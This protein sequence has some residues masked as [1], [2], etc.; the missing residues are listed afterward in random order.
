LIGSG[1]STGTASQRLQVTGGAYVSGR[2][3]VANTNPS[4]V[5]DVT[6]SIGITTTS[7]DALIL[8]STLTNGRTSIVLNT[9]GNDWELGSRGSGSSPINSFYIYDRNASAYRQV[10]DP[11]GNVLFGATSATGTAS[12][13]LQVTGGGYFSGSVGIGSTNPQSTLSVGGTITEL[14][15][16]TYWNVVTQ[17]DVGYGSSQVPLNQYL[18]QLA[19][20]DDFSPNGLRREG[21]GSDD[22]GISS[23]GYV[24][25]GTTNPTSKLHVVGDGY[26]TGIVTATDFNSASDENLKTNIVTIDDPL[27][28]IVQIRGVNFEWR[29]NGR[30]SAGVIAQEIEKVLPELVNGGETKTVNYNGLIGLLIEAIKAQQEEI[31]I[32]KEKIK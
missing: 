16:G 2:L 30:R 27:D 17:A 11:S 4:Y 3:G 20:L 25:I 12:Q 15:A 19:F 1:T 18:G 22:V 10:I 28:K 5:I 7:G 13:L 26:F 14:Y 29:E 6:G 31:D 8:S 21:G 9:N 24:G 23:I 32:L